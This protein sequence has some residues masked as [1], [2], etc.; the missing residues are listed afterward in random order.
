MLKLTS[1]YIFNIDYIWEILEKV[2]FIEPL[3]KKREDFKKFLKTVR[4]CI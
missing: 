4:L 2:D 1:H 3:G